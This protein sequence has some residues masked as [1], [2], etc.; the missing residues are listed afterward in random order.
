M[1]TTTYPLPPPQTPL[2]QLS[3]SEAARLLLHRRT[4]RRDLKVWCIEALAHSGQRPARHHARLLDRL[5]AVSRGEVERLMVLMPPGSAKSTYASMLFPAWYLAN[6]PD[7]AVIAASHTAD[8]AERFGRR[9]RNLIVEHAATLGVSL[10]SDVQA[11]GQWETTERGEY[12]A[13]GV[14]G[15]IT[16]RRADLVIIDDP[17]KSRQEADSEII[18]E[19]VW[20]W[21]KSDLSTRLKPG[22]RV[23]L[24]MC[25]VGSTKVLMADGTERPLRDIRTGD[26]IATYDDGKLSVSTIVNW[27]SQGIDDILQIRTESG[28][29]SRANARHPFLME[30]NGLRE[31]VRLQ[32]IREGDSILR[33][34]PN[35]APTS[36][37]LACSKDVGNRRSAGDIAFPITTKRDGLKAFG[38]HQSTPAREGPHAYCTDMGSQTRSISDYSRSRAD[39]ALSAE[40]LLPIGAGDSVSITTTKQGRSER[41]CATTA[42][43]QLDMGRTK[44]RCG[45]PQNTSEFILDRVISIVR[46][47]RDEVFDVQV[48]H[49]ANFIA[50]GFVSH[51]TRWHEDDLGGRLLQDM[52]TGGRQWEVLRLP[53]EA[54]ANDPIWRTVGEPLWPEW[55]T[56]A[57]RADAKRD[58]RT[59][60]ALYQQSPSPGTGS[61]FL[62]EWL[63]PVTSLPPRESLRIYGGSDYA[64]T[65]DGGDYTVHVVIGLDS[66]H[67]LWLLDLWRGQTASDVWVETF[68][69]LVRQWRPM[70]WAEEQGQIKAGVGPFL[71]RR[72]RERQAY[73]AREGFP[74]RGDKS[75]RAQAIRGRMALDGLYIPA[76][77]PWRAALEAELLTFPVGKHDDQVDALGLIGQLLDRMVAPSPA[78]DPD[79][80]I[81]GAADMTL[82]EAWKI[83]NPRERVGRGR[84]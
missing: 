43:S 2:S 35:G 62:S 71:R 5:E 84:I 58:V 8:L 41:S 46:C 36:A 4:I 33:V 18:R 44:P 54:E 13:A 73:V 28:A 51:N 83:A 77:A 61:Y 39:S 14:M 45:Q 9:V 79:A 48:A 34:L 37:S 65:D 59:W 19:R 53:M 52:A 6:H 7:H 31:W 10:A 25:M 67:R 17:V 80:P 57:M 76:Y 3:P 38:H 78:R 60:S 63:R 40:N 69:D 26:K 47:G 72:M 50:D 74:T 11:A 75:V 42:I 16:G 24:I 15:P 56:D 81:R 27:K 49:T 32:N 22:A 12:Y 23:V 1:S 55:F 82:N 64:V 70:A 20:E 30:R 21:W 29:V 66:D 68:C